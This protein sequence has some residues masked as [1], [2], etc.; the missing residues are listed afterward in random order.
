MPTPTESGVEVVTEFGSRVASLCQQYVAALDKVKIR[1]AAQKFM[2][3][4]AAGNKFF[5]VQTPPC[6]SVANGI[7]G[8]QV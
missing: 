8:R 3:I 4:S 7:S 5:Q 2:A 1:E 6:Y